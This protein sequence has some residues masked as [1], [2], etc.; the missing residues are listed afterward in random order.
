LVKPSPPRLLQSLRPSPQLRESN[1]PQSGV[2]GAPAAGGLHS[3]DGWGT[4]PT[5]M[6]SAYGLAGS[7]LDETPAM[8]LVPSA[9]G[10]M[11]HGSSAGSRLA[12]VTGL[13]DSE[14][15]TSMAVIPPPR[16]S[17]SSLPAGQDGGG[18]VSATVSPTAT[19]GVG[20]W[21]RGVGATSGDGAD[22][23]T[24]AAAEALLAVPKGAT[25]RPQPSSSRLAPH[26][27]TQHP[28]TSSPAPVYRRGSSRMVLALG[29]SGEAANPYKQRRGI[30][31]VADNALA[32]AMNILTVMHAANQA[33]GKLARFLRPRPGVPPMGVTEFK[34]G[35]G[36][37]IGYAVGES[38][39]AG[40]GP[41]G[42][43]L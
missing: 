4:Q 36:M 9:D 30:Q 25:L 14:A 7:S 43:G 29:A 42:G 15:G 33:G 34:L 5:S 10:T 28:A 31:A 38:D 23:S 22:A 21:H 20:G 27:L 18:D 41:P 3:V 11:L 40:L 2:L 16:Q 24:H 37:H 1:Q 35:F 17:R 32:A 13:V 6:G 12:T 39:V 26:T 8:Q 19:R